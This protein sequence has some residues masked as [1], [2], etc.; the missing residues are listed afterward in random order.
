MDTSAPLQSALPEW[1]ND[2]PPMV[3]TSQP[4]PLCAPCIALFN[5]PLGDRINWSKVLGSEPDALLPYL[6]GEQP[7]PEFQ[8]VSLGYAG[9]QFGIFAAQLGDGRAHL[10]ARLQAGQLSYEL[11]LKGSGK[12]PWT[13]SGD[14]RL[15][16]SAALREY[17]YSEALAGLGI[18]TTRTLAV[19][20]SIRTVRRNPA[21][22]AAILSRLSTSHLRIG[23]IEWLSVRHE[24]ATMDAI[25]K[26]M[27]QPTRS[28]PLLCYADWFSALC[29]RLADLGGHWMS[30]GFVHGVLNTDNISLVGETL[31]LGPCAFIDIFDAN[32][33]FSAVD[34]AGRYRFAAQ[35]HAL[36]WAL[37]KLAQCIKQRLENASRELPELS[38]EL[39]TQLQRVE[40]ALVNFAPSLESAW[41][42]RLAQRLGLQGISKANHTLC[43]SWLSLLHQNKVDYNRAFDEL[44][45]WLIEDT[46]TQCM[47]GWLGTDAGRAWLADYRQAAPDLVRM[48]QANPA[49]SPR[50]AWVEDLVV[51]ACNDH[52]FSRIEKFLVACRQ[53]FA[54]PP[55]QWQHSAAVQPKGLQRTFCGT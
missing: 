19:V 40:H 35:P 47:P 52:D 24:W 6:S 49:F 36:F 30:A 11:Q 33:C 8:S 43:Q 34:S 51:A 32:A 18:P 42:S 29:Q 3:R 55:A 28:H 14:G 44:C 25:I 45:S 9:H 13:L 1:L 37:S 5:H 10:I 46:H 17:I 16:L 50:L 53:P 54:S 39:N 27:Q 4:E 41:L 15:S 20:F 12:T 38:T 21:E 31:D 7:W 48:R 22:P 2:N 23:T 26:G